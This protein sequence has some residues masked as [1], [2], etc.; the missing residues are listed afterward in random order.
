MCGAQPG[1]PV[2]TPVPFAATMVPS[3]SQSQGWSGGFDEVHAVITPAQSSTYE[4]AACGQH[5]KLPLSAAVAT[6]GVAHAVCPSDALPPPAMLRRS[7]TSSRST[8][9]ILHATVEVG[10]APRGSRQQHLLRRSSHII[11]RHA[12]GIIGV[13]KTGISIWPANRR[14]KCTTPGVDNR[15]FVLSLFDTL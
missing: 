8:A 1:R 6:G 12:S 9:I 2:S 13:Y 14:Q 10:H 11:Q 3:A 4:A 5:G 15:I 7:S